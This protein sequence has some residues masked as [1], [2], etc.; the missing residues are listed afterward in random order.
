MNSADADLRFP[1]LCF[2]NQL[3]MHAAT[4]LAELTTWRSH[5][6][7]PRQSELGME[8]IDS[9]G[10]RFA[11]RAIDP[12]PIEAPWLKRAFKRLLPPPKM[13]GRIRS[14]PHAPISTPK[15]TA[16]TLITVP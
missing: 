5:A 13:P 6:L 12:P 15:P 9:Q 7:K 11:V 10:Q 16:M 3:G 8:I 4:T 1:V 2:T 14:R